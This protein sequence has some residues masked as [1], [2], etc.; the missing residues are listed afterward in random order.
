MC[1]PLLV[2]GNCTT[3]K[4]SLGAG[5]VRNGVYDLVIEADDFWYYVS[6]LD[7]AW[8]MSNP[9]NG[10]HRNLKNEALSRCLM[11][12]TRHYRVVVTGLWPGESQPVLEKLQNYAVI[13][14]DFRAVDS[15]GETGLSAREIM[16]RRFVARGQDKAELEKSRVLQ[17]F[18]RNQADLLAFSAKMVQKGHYCGD[19]RV[20]D[21][22]W[23]GTTVMPVEI[24]NL[25][26][27]ARG[28]ENGEEASL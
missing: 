17:D 11:A 12:L 18:E 20:F 10:V 2:Y 26:L 9:K 7:H 23:E 28:E 22:L 19:P 16:V 25:K 5:L 15:L 21:T 8:R 1:N 13:V 24:A 14:L 3:G 6:G 4:S 27:V